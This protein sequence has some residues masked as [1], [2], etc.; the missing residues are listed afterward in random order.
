LPSLAFGLGTYGLLAFSIPSLSLGHTA[1]PFF[2]L[3]KLAP[4]FASL[5]EQAN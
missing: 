2:L 4:A 1:S 3:K 5:Q